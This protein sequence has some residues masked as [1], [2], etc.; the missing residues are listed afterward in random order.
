MTRTIQSLHNCRWLTP[1]EAP[2]DRQL[3]HFTTRSSSETNLD[4]PWP[5]YPDLARLFI[6]PSSSHNSSTPLNISARHLDGRCCFIV[7]KWRIPAQNGNLLE[8]LSSWTE[9]SFFPRKMTWFALPLRSFAQTLRYS[10][11]WSVQ[12]CLSS[13]VQDMTPEGVLW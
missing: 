9:E 11:Y 1:C 12:L 8:E 13:T 5:S 4:C 10:V 7:Q 2:R 6:S 3:L